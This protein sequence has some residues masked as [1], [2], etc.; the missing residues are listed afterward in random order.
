[1]ISR[2]IKSDQI[3]NAD[4]IKTIGITQKMISDGISS[5]YQI[6]DLIDNTLVSENSGR[7]AEIVE[8]ANLSSI[9]GNLL[10]S[11]ISKA[12]SKKFIRNGPHKY[13][14]VL[15]AS[16]DVEDF[17]IKVALECNKPKGHLAKEGHYITFRY[18][19][20]D[21]NGDFLKGIEN[22]KN[23]PW[24]WEVRCGY[25]LESDFN[26]S[27]T[28]GDSGKTAVISKNGWDKMKILFEDMRFSPR[29]TSQK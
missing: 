17:E 25:I 29:A 23:V 7:L 27:N 9:I 12:S 22:R 28:D 10:G 14:D 18:V 11:G 19:L 13:P 2:K 16:P 8:L 5:T 24:I 26:I 4:E 20:A 1:L 3:D 15:A 6:I 21:V